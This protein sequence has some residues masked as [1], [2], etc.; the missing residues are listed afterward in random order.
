[1]TGDKRAD[2]VGAHSNGSVYVWPGQANG[3][4]GT[5]VPS[6]AGTFDLANLDGTGYQIVGIADVTGDGR[7]DLVGSHTN[8]TTYVWPGQVSGA[9]ATH[10]PSLSG[11]VDMAHFDG[12]GHFLL[13]VAGVTGDGRADPPPFH[14]WRW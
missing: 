13:N 3:T 7:A 14:G 5:H 11:A 9:F 10:V 1:M 12:S 4:F 2:L 8:L 6:F